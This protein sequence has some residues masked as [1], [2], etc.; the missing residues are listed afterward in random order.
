MRIISQLIIDSNAKMYDF[1]IFWRLK[2]IEIY[3]IEKFC[4][5]DGPIF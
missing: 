5:K 4:S 2:A 3:T 1:D